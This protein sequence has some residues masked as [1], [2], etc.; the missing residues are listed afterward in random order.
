M[1]GRPMEEW[2]PYY[3]KPEYT[4]PCGSE[5]PP[6]WVPEHVAPTAK[7]SAAERQAEYMRRQLDF[8]M[9]GAERAEALFIARELLGDRPGNQ[10]PMGIAHRI[11]RAERTLFAH[12]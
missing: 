2:D 10:T 1:S 4:G 9:T 8:K 11:K 6:M 7:W 5:W 12:S 3:L